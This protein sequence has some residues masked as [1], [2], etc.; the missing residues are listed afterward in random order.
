MDRVRRG[1]VS[2]TVVTLQKKFGMKSQ[3]SPTESPTQG[4][5]AA[6]ASPS[7]PELLQLPPAQMENVPNQHLQSDSASSNTPVLLFELDRPSIS[8]ADVD[9]ASVSESHVPASSSSQPPP[10]SAHISSAAV[11]SSDPRDSSASLRRS[12]PSSEPQPTKAAAPHLP[13][14]R[15]NRNALHLAIV[16]GSADVVQQLLHSNPEYLNDVDHEGHTPVSL[17][18]QLV[19][20]AVGAVLRTAGL[21]RHRHISELPQGDLL[22]RESWD[23]NFKICKLLSEHVRK[24]KEWTS[25]FEYVSQ[26]RRS[27]AAACFSNISSI[28]SRNMSLFQESQ[29]RTEQRN[30]ALRLAS[31][32]KS[33]CFRRNCS[34][35]A[36]DRRCA[37]AQTRIACAIR[38]H[39]A[40]L[41]LFLKR[42]TLN[43]Q[44]AVRIHNLFLRHKC[45]RSTRALAARTIQGAWRNRVPHR[46]MQES[47][48]AL[49]LRQALLLA[50]HVLHRAFKFFAAR[51]ALNNARAEF[52]H[53]L[54]M[55]EIAQQNQKTGSFAIRLQSAMRCAR[56]CKLYSR[57]V[58]QRV[59]TKIQC[60]YRAHIARTRAASVSAD[61]SA[62]V[63]FKSGYCFS[64]FGVSGFVPKMRINLGGFVAR[65]TS[66]LQRAWRGRSAR[67]LMA[68]MALRRAHAGARILQLVYI[69]HLHFEW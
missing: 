65:C 66:K 23:S 19:N 33:R 58:R 1:S 41:V 40:K 17:S 39:N 51:L 24:Q 38:V 15:R 53:R 3:S 18:L 12:I 20:S 48:R 22:R 55:I 26:H 47:K 29:W 7:S 14:L 27:F 30:L 16:A 63:A 54:K 32:F 35:R 50:R 13:I 36:S 10:A 25:S 67:L 11:S 56:A 4:P 59:A 43:S 44:A 34:K 28:L 64:I 46:T 69:R 9:V 37:L 6:D 49:Q 5:T 52:M 57:L 2:G 45:R 62:L 61:E 31:I 42:H 68:R 60:I 21:C 8:A